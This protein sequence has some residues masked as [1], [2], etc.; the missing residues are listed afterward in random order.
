MKK[1]LLMNNKKILSLVATAL[2]IGT[3]LVGG[4]VALFNASTGGLNNV[5]EFGK[6]NIGVVLSNHN[7]L[8]DEVAYEDFYSAFLAPSQ[9]VNGVR[10]KNIDSDA[11]PTVDTYVRVR[12]VAIWRDAA[13]NGTGKEVNLNYTKGGF[14]IGGVVDNWVYNSSDGYW[15]YKDILSPDEISEIFIDGYSLVD[16]E[17]TD[18]GHLEIQVLADGVM[19]TDS[20]LLNAWGV[21][22]SQINSW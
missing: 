3:L 2:L 12:V 4:S 5:I 7:G 15:Y 8:D 18:G 6:V 19:A 17:P 10:I 14:A 21:T 1:I 11:Y 20:A 13:G 9:I 22:I 16:S